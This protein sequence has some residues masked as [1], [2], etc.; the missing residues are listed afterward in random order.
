MSKNRRA[1][2]GDSSAQ[3]PVRSRESRDAGIV[4]DFKEMFRD[5]VGSLIYCTYSADA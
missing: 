2:D 5:D 3:E 1:H 4:Y